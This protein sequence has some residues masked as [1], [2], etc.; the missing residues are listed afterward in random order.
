[1][2]TP[3]IEATTI[4][5]PATAVSGAD[6]DI[7]GLPA[8]TTSHFLLVTSGTAA[9]QYESITGTSGDTATLENAIAG[10]AVADTV[11]VIEHSTLGTL[12]TASGSTIPDNTTLT[13]YNSDGSSDAYIAASNNWYNLD[14]FALS[15]GVIIFP[16]EGVTMSFADSCTLTFTGTVNTDPITIS[17]TSGVVNLVGSLNPSTPAS[18]DSIGS[19][20]GTLD[21]NSTL[22]IYSNDGSL[23]TLG[24]YILAS[25]NWYNLDG[26]ALT[27]I[28][29]AAPLAISLSPAATSDVTLP[30][31]YTAP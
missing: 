22:T 16:G 4:A 25:G 20:L 11:K 3:L 31:A 14:G 8:L 5:G 1:V 12:H 7:A 15:D 10:L 24:T 13:V 9:G 26:F 6:V 30:A 21:D 28:S 17:A 18:P 23:T 27:D 29:E 2:S 19:G